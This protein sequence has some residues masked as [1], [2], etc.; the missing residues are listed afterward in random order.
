VLGFCICRGLHPERT[1]AASAR[2]LKV[3]HLHL[4]MLTVALRET[5]R[6]GYGGANADSRSLE[7]AMRAE[8]L[9]PHQQAIWLFRLIKIL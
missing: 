1:D 9:N 4:K 2:C 5:R 3:K 7:K 8:I 6:P